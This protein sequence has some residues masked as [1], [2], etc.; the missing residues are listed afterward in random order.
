MNIS[1]KIKTLSTRDV[2]AHTWSEPPKEQPQ[3]ECLKIWEQPK[4]GH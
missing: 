1:L 3:M 2:Q 4:M